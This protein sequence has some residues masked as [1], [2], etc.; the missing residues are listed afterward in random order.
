[1]AQQVED[2]M[3]Y[4]SLGS[5]GLSLSALGV[6]TWEIGNTAYG[7]TN[8][9]EASAAVQRALDLGI[10]TFD[11]AP[12][13][14]QGAAETLL[15]KALGRRRDE[16]VLISKCGLTW[17]ER[18]GGFDWRRDAS[19]ARIQTE[20]DESLRRLGTDWLDVYLVHWPDPE[21]PV[22]ETASAMTDII[23]AGKARCAGIS[24]VTRE[25][26]N[27]FHQLCPVS[28]VQLGYNLFDRRIE[29]SLLP[30]C[31]EQGISVMA[32]GA[33]CYGLLTGSFTSQTRFDPTDWRAEG[34]AFGLDLFTPENF[35]ANIAVVD[36]LRPLAAKLG[37]TLPQL[38]LNWL[39][40]RPGIV[41]GLTGVRKPAEI[42][43][44][45]GAL[46]WR[47]TAPDLDAIDR[48]FA[49]AAGN[50]GPLPEWC[51]PGNPSEGGGAH[52]DCR[53]ANHCGREPLEELGLRPA[54][55]GRRDRG[56]R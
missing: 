44:N 4:R 8:D 23:R 5:S 47:L 43:D 17:Q 32:Y 40:N 30:Y 46:G 35:A 14:G 34:R 52:E 55:Y 24:N 38:A 25:Q 3:E 10:T 29:E 2:F 7:H 42:D 28:V 53:R 39:V 26:L 45:A 54:R 49:N 20:I 56:H 50:R 16:V 11:T 48:I 36:A 6:G 15:G 33:L 9:G 19:P 13:Y 27:T 31:R 37:K 21:T 1:M 41:A 12:A 51:A 18:A 22:A